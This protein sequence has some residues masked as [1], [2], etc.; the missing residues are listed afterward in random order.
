MCYAKCNALRSLFQLY[1]RALLNE[2]A[3]YLSYISFNIVC[4]DVYQIFD[5]R[6]NKIKI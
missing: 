4:Y 3:T 1:L 6:N 5:N 2:V